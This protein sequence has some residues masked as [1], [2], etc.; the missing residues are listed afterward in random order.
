MMRSNN[1][2]V[3]ALIVSVFINVFVIQ[4][5]VRSVED[6]FIRK[7]DKFYAARYNMEVERFNSPSFKKEIY[8]DCI[9]NDPRTCNR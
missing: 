4:R 5:G 9:F 2:I 7:I 6:H 1:L 8:D 3:A